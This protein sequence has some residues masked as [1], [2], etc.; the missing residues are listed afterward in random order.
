MEDYDSGT[1]S[2]GR[3][4]YMAIVLCLVVGVPVFVFFNIVTGGL[5]I[6]L[7]VLMAGVGVLGVINYFLWGRGFSRETAGEREEEQLRARMEA[8]DWPYDDRPERRH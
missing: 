5:F 8:E 1:R 7:L 3:D 4:T 6:L 2:S